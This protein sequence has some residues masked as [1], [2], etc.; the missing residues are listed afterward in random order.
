MLYM[1]LPQLPLNRPRNLQLVLDI[2]DIVDLV[3]KQTNYG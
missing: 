2:V 3:D 1:A